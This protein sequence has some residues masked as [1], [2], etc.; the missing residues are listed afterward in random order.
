MINEKPTIWDH[1]ICLFGIPTLIM[2]GGVFLLVMTN[3]RNGALQFIPTIFILL[4]LAELVRSVARM[5]YVLTRRQQTEI[6]QKSG[7]GTYILSFITTIISIL[8]FVMGKMTL[9]SVLYIQLSIAI[10]IYPILQ[11]VFIVRD[12]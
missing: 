10:L 2:T 1:P 7:Y 6:N 8:F 11:L 12:S 9:E 3:A 5:Q 4:G